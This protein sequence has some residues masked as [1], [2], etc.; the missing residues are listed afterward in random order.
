MHCNRRASNLRYCT[1]A[2]HIPARVALLGHSFYREFH[3]TCGAVILLKVSP[4]TLEIER[5]RYFSYRKRNI[6]LLCVL[7][8]WSAHNFTT[9]IQNRLQGTI[10]FWYWAT[11]PDLMLKNK[12]RE[13]SVRVF[14]PELFTK[15]CSITVA[16][17][18][19]KQ[20]LVRSPILLAG[21]WTSVITAILLVNS[22][23]CRT[24]SLAESH[25]FYKFATK[26]SEHL[27]ARYI[28]PK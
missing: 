8:T 25:L 18:R 4:N 22:T 20:Y 13:T 16:A 6:G 3:N 15:V 26:K 24:S 7:T 9:A 1:G 14:R 21:F 11:L 2:S 19:K 17:S 5:V 10:Y 28:V 23:N 12:F 27:C